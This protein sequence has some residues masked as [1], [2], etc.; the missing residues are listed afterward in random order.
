MIRYGFILVLWAHCLSADLWL[1]DNDA[2]QLEIGNNTLFVS[3][4][5]S[6]VPAGLLR[7]CGMRKVAFP[8]DWLISIDN[9][10][11]IKAIREDFRNFLNEDFL[12]PDNFLLRNASGASL[13]HLDYHFEFVHEGDFF[14]LEYVQNW[15]SLMERYQ[16]RIERFNKIAGYP[17]TVIFLRCSYRMGL[18]DPHRYFKCKEIIDISDEDAMSLYWTLKERFQTLR[19]KLVIMNEGDPPFSGIVVE[20]RLNDDVFKVRHCYPTQPE[21]FSEFGKFLV[22]N[23]CREEQ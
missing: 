18:T 2:D 17:G 19:F 8:L 1:V 11:L 20:S 6:C 21:L 16:R 12:I 23:F 4:G 15:Q 5:S 7:Y 13:I 14:G 3:L 22:E 10:G 9:E